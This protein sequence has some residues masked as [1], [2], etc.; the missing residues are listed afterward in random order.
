MPKRKASEAPAG[1]EGRALRARKQKS[2]TDDDE[3]LVAALK[4]AEAAETRRSM[5]TSAAEAAGLPPYSLAEFERGCGALPD[6]LKRQPDR[7]VAL[8]NHILA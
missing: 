2:Y 7:L 8:R 4:Y 5:D 1:S 3:A 6:A